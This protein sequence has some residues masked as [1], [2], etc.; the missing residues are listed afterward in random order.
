MKRALP[1]V[2]SKSVSAS[3]EP[4]RPP[5]TTGSA[6]KPEVVQGR[7]RVVD[8]GAFE[9]GGLIV[10]LDGV[11]GERGAMADQLDRLLRR[12]PISCQPTN[13]RDAYQCKI[14]E[15]DLAE[16]IV[17]GGGARVRSDAPSYLFDAE[18][19]ARSERLGIW[20]R[21]RR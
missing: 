2:K 6:S 20:R 10:Q 11:V 15:N 7:A 9:I 16:I 5:S 4:A 19:F 21:S 3:L 14:G 18:E 17:A 1:A 13:N 8:T 12:R